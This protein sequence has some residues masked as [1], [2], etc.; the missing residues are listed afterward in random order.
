MQYCSLQHRTLLL[1]PVTS[2]TGYCFSLAPSLHSFSSYFSPDLQQHIGYLMTWGVPCSESYHFAFSYCSWVSQGKNT[3]IKR[4]LLLGRKVMTN[5]GSIF[6]S[7][8]IT[9]PTKVRLVKAMVF[10]LV[11]YGCESWTVRKAARPVFSAIWFLSVWF[12]AIQTLYCRYWWHSGKQTQLLCQ[13]RS[14]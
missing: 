12:L 6:K 13:Q 8:D 5:L 4:R 11:I 14:V 1:S 7:R 3:E 9:L 10:P 2:A